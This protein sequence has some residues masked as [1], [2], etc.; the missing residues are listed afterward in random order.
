VVVQQHDV[1]LAEVALQ[2]RPLGEIERDALVVVIGEIGRT[3]CAVWL[4][5]RRPRA[6]RDRRAVRR[7]QMHDAA[8]VLAHLMHRGMDGEAGGID[9]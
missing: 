3:S 5:G 9:G 7:V 1:L 8:G 2:P 6:S 4:S